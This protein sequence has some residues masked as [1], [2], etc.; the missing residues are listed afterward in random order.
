[1]RMNFGDR[2]LDVA[3]ISILAMYDET[4]GGLGYWGDYTLFPTY[5]VWS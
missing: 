1:M 3:E 2:L 4:V 5:P